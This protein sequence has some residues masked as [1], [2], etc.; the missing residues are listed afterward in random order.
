VVGPKSS[1]ATD[2]HGNNSTDMMVSEG[3]VEGT[4]GYHQGRIR[5]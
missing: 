2:M 3:A 1:S 5:N 4:D